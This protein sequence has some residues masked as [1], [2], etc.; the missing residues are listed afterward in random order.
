MYRSKGG[1]RKTQQHYLTTKSVA[2]EVLMVLEQSIC[3][4]TDEY[5]VVAVRAT[6]KVLR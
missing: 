5:L 2:R 4:P 3:Y 1:I 6:M